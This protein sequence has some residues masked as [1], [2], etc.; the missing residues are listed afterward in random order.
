MKTDKKFIDEDLIYDGLSLRSVKDELI[1][2][3]IPYEFAGWYIQQFIKIAYAFHCRENFYM[4]WDA[5]TIPLRR[6]EFFNEND[7]PYLTLKKEYHKCYFDTC[8][9]LIGIN[10]QINE[11]F[12]S[13]HML[14]KVDII[15]ELI[16]K[17]EMNKS[18]NGEYFWK[19]IIHAASFS[20]HFQS[21]SEFE[22]I[23]SYI[24]A[25]YSD[26]Y[27][28][29][30]L[31][32]LRTCEVYIKKSNINKMQKWI[33]KDFDMVS[34]EGLYDSNKYTRITRRI[35]RCCRYFLSFKKFILHFKNE[36]K[37]VYC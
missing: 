28:L 10:K 1:L 30:R 19:K 34:F 4:V 36:A 12:I 20:D 23:G 27:A 6:I 3:K 13:E 18:L 35:V 15:K 17:I 11:S 37:V 5:D 29:R 2:N 25:Y 33:S 31:H 24:K 21:F 7:T 8:N 32:T 14:I 22:T 26:Q 9:R 16:L